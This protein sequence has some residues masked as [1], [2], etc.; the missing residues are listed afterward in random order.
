MDE[1][2]R[3]QVGDQCE[4]AGSPEGDEDREVVV[5]VA[6]LL[7]AE[8]ARAEAVLV[9][10]V[11]AEDEEAEE[12]ERREEAVAAG[13]GVRVPEDDGP[14]EREAHRS[15]DPGQQ[16]RDEPR[17]HHLPHSSPRNGGR[18]DRH[19]HAD[20]GADD[21]VGRGHGGTYGRA[22]H[23]PQPGAHQRGHH[24]N[25]QH[26]RVV[27]EVVLVQDTLAYGLRH[28]RTHEHYAQELTEG[29][30]DAG[31]LEC[32]RFGADRGSE[33][34]RTVIGSDAVSLEEEGQESEHADP[35]EALLK[36]LD[37]PKDFG[38][39]HDRAD[40]HGGQPCGD[41]CTRHHCEHPRK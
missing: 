36:L 40:G 35:C 14:R 29:R 20:D 1:P 4:Q 18:V 10:H 8:L 26:L 12:E 27:Q 19:A 13:N 34:V 16:G 39:V 7:E 21:G 33:A 25:H 24:A 2:A 41:N 9:D 22:D 38:R 37:V 30:D 17:D 32:Q 3:Q 15:K 31:L 6:P 23:Q 11:G 5:G 28:L